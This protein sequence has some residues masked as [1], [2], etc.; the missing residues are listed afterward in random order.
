MPPVIP[1][2]RV[3]EWDACLRALADLAMTRDEPENDPANQG[4]EL[5][6][7]YLDSKS[8]K[9]QMDFDTEEWQRCARNNQPFRHDGNIYIHCRQWHIDYLRY[10]TD[11][12][13]AEALALLRK[14]GT[15]TQI[16][17]RHPNT[18]RYY[19]K[20]PGEGLFEVDDD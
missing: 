14:L 10:F 9:F 20:M 5:V 1:P 11:V 13:Y 7:S 12:T 4:R 6:R 2:K 18:S 19:W 15:N 8:Y 3:D 17:L 16:S